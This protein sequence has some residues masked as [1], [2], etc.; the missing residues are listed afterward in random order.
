MITSL[1]EPC[2]I[3]S[4]YAVRHLVHSV[5]STVL[6][7]QQ[8]ACCSACA[9]SPWYH[10]WACSS[11]FAGYN[12]RTSA[13]ALI[14]QDGIVQEG[15]YSLSLAQAFFLQF[16]TQFTQ[17]QNMECIRSCM[18]CTGTTCTLL[19]EKHAAIFFNTKWK[20]YVHPFEFTETLKR[21]IVGILK[22][23]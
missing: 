22:C 9:Q 10:R 19:W 5:S 8:L 1:P 11:I 4:N 13:A 21:L 23:T 7:E 3:I 15:V 14:I 17:T 16:V 2:L 20:A 12:T 6:P 18:W